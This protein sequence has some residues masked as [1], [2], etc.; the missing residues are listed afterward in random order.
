MMGPLSKAFKCP[1]LCQN[2]SILF[3]N[4]FTDV[5]SMTAWDNSFYSCTTRWLKKNLLMSRLARCFDNFVFD[6]FQ[7]PAS[8]YT[9][10][11]MIKAP[12]LRTAADTVKC[13]WTLEER[14]VR[15]D[16]IE[17]YKMVNGMSGISFDSFL[18]YDPNGRTRGHSKKLRK[19]RF[20]TDLRKHFFTDRIINIWNALDDRTV[21]S[22]T[23]NSFKN[24]LERLWNSRRM[25]LLWSSVAKDPWGRASLLLVKPR[26]WV[27]GECPLKLYSQAD[28]WRNWSRSTAI[29][30][31]IIIYASMRSHR[32]RRS[33]KN[34][35]PKR[36]NLFSRFLQK[37]AYAR[38]TSTFD[39]TIDIKP[40]WN[41]N[42]ASCSVFLLM[43]F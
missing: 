11:S 2:L 9:Y 5:E 31:V 38:Q 35:S 32:I 17:V 16:L 25:G 40:L 37:V 41:W 15:A 43:C 18:E 36:F 28:N 14:R 13:L 39:D 1:Y 23:L 29:L 4:W 30:L 19:K 3:L 7:H 33:S 27:I 6:N 10:G 20:N 21:T 26:R 22:A 34:A 12:A 24:G 42:D 8:V